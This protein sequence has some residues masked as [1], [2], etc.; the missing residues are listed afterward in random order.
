ML[1]SNS[2]SEFIP[3]APT[4]RDSPLEFAESLSMGFLY[5]HDEKKTEGLRGEGDRG[6]K[7][8]ELSLIFK[9]WEPGGWTLLG[10]HLPGLRLRRLSANPELRFCLI[11]SSFAFLE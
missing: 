4:T 2:Y 3:T 8:L 1:V 7:E 9:A 5:P 10:S 11:V 6:E